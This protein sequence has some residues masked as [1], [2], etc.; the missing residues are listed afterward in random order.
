MKRTLLLFD[1]DGTLMLS[2]GAGMRSMYIVAERMFGADFSWDGIDPQ[3]NIDP[4]IFAEAAAKNGKDGPAHHDTFRDGYIEQLRHELYAGRD[5]VR[6]LPGVRN[7][8]AVLRDRARK[9]GDVVLGLL[10]GNYARA[11][12]IKLASVDLDPSWFEI[13]A[14]G[15]EA[16]TRPGLV[17]LAMSRYEVTYGEPAEPQRVWIVGD[18]PRDVACAHAHGCRCFAVATGFSS[19]DDLRQADADV[20]VDDLVDPAPLLALIDQP[21]PS[22]GKP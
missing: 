10:T 12:P 21:A 13:T 8:L 5:G 18:T 19:P 22:T 14:F 9:Q 20:L 1:I 3:G 6:I 17:L 11:V 4:A 16:E 7:A 15:D 2:G